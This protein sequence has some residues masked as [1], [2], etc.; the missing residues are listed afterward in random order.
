MRKVK[1]L[2]KFIFKKLKNATEDFLLELGVTY[3]CGCCTERY[4]IYVD[5]EELESLQEDDYISYFENKAA[6]TIFSTLEWCFKDE[7]LWL[8]YYQED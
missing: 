8:N 4:S 1:D 2:S 6:L 7:V 3:A 5:K